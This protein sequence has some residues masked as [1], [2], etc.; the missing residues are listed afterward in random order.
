[1]Y[2]RL[3]SILF[4]TLLLS[5]TGEAR[6]PIHSAVR[7]AAGFATAIIGGR[8]QIEK[9][10][11]QALLQKTIMIKGAGKGNLCSGIVLCRKYVLTGG[12]CLEKGDHSIFRG[13]RPDLKA[14]VGKGSE[15]VTLGKA[16]AAND[17]GILTLE[18]LVDADLSFNLDVLAPKDSFPKRGERAFI[19]G[20]GIYSTEEHWKDDSVTYKNVGEGIRRGGY[21]RVVAQATFEDKGEKSGNF[22][23]TAR[24][25][26]ATA[27]GG[28]GDSGGPLFID[29]VLHGVFVAGRSDPN[30]RNEPSLA[31]NTTYGLYSPVAEHRAWILE[32]L[33]RRPECRRRED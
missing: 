9:E 24:G 15:F 12:H 22:I 14:P 1:M 10:S 25:P 4:V 2:A 6:P 32:Q 29:G 33:E 21:S 31:D 13:A 5:T 20:Y 8:P 16:K 18:K 28:P 3:G 27:L 26:Q 30:F 23:L 11:D 17:I 7:K 19:A